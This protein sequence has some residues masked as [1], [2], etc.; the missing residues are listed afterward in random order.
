MR[1]QIGERVEVVAG[2]KW[3]FG[4]ATCDIVEMALGPDDDGLLIATL[5]V[6]PASEHCS[7]SAE[8]TAVE[9]SELLVQFVA[10]EPGQ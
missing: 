8:T 2:L 3:T 10:R 6:T 5:G 1:G 7:P 9:E 4:G